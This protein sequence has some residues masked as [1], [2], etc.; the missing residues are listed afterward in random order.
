MIQLPDVFPE[1][2]EFM[3]KHKRAIDYASNDLRA[4]GKVNMG[5]HITQSEHPATSEKT[6]SSEIAKNQNRTEF[7]KDKVSGKSNDPK[8]W[9]WLHSTSNHGILECRTF[10]DMTHESRLDVAYEYGVCWGCLQ[11]GHVQARCF[12]PKECSVDGCKRK[13]H[14]MLHKARAEPSHDENADDNKNK[15]E[16]TSAQAPLRVVD[17]DN[18]SKKL[19]F[20]ECS[21][22]QP[23]LLQIMQLRAGIRHTI[24]MNVLWDSGAQ[25]SLITLQ[26][27]KELG[28][29]G[30]CT[31][32]T[33]VKI[34]NIKENV[35]SRIYDVP[36]VDSSGEV[37]MIKA[38]GI[39]QISSKIEAIEIDSLAKE[40][41]VNP[42]GLERPKGEL[43]ML[44]GYDYAGF[45]PEKL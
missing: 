35:D 3:L 26:K 10:K 12:K 4:S 22:G 29:T 18:D 7:S 5:V 9:C 36:L 45:L 21:T 34:G 30:T 44:V 43:E 24:K 39:P 19:N 16:D 27:A 1:M 41:G 40:L 14:Q 11:P 23:G 17:N 13:H 2:L 15:K 31:S 6:P 37:E 25:I 33:I 20:S 8:S 38:Y 32:L 28:L 42:D